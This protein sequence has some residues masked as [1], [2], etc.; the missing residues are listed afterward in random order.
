MK[1][2]ESTSTMKYQSRAK[3]LHEDFNKQMKEYYAR[4]LNHIMSLLHKLRHIKK[5]Y[6]HKYINIYGIKY[7]CVFYIVD[8]FKAIYVPSKYATY[9]YSYMGVIDNKINY[10]TFYFRCLSYHNGVFEI[11]K[12]TN[13]FKCIEIHDHFLR[14]THFDIMYFDK[15]KVLKGCIADS[16]C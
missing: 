2:K 15:E 6:S 13:C 16:P 1:S 11:P 10:K 4:P 12:R 9:L 3:I 7:L 5:L 8:D 14:T